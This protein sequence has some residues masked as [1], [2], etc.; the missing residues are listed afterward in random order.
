MRQINCIIP[1]RVSIS[2]SPEDLPDG[3][4]DVELRS[5]IAAGVQSRLHFAW[6]QLQKKYGAIPPPQFHTPEI[7]FSKD[8]PSEARL[9]LR[10]IILRGIGDGISGRAH[11][12]AQPQFILAD[13]KVPSRNQKPVHP[14]EITFKKKFHIRLRDYADLS[15][16]WKDV[17]ARKARNE[18]LDALYADRMDDVLTA[19]AWVVTVKK[20]MLVDDLTEDLTDLVQTLPDNAGKFISWSWN[21]TDGARLDLANAAQGSELSDLPSL[22]NNPGGQLPDGRTFLYFRGKLLF[23]F[24]SLPSLELTTL[25]DLQNPITVRVLL[26][27]LTPWINEPQFFEFFRISWQ[28]YVREFGDNE[29]TLTIQPFITNQKAT[30]ASL[31]YLLRE[32]VV[33]ILAEDQAVFGHLRILNAETVA[34]LPPPARTALLKDWPSNS[35]TSVPG[36]Q[37]NG[38]WEDGWTGAYIHTIVGP[39]LDEP[40]V[41]SYRPHARDAA[42]KA[43]EFL[44]NRENTYHWP[45]RFL[46]FLVTEFRTN[47]YRRNRTPYVAFQYFLKELEQRDGGRWFN[48]LFDAIEAAH[49]GDLYYF[50]LQITQ[51]TNYASHPRVVRNKQLFNARRRDYLANE[52]DI[53]NKQIVLDKNPSYRMGRGDFLKALSRTEKRIEPARLAELQVAVDRISKEFLGK[54]LRGEDSNTYSKEEFAQAVLTQA[55]KEINLSNDDMEKV[56]VTRR[57]KFIDLDAKNEGGIE[58][59]YI[60][61]EYYDQIEDEPLVLVPNSR[62]TVTDSDLEFMLWSWD[63]Q[64]VA[65]FWDTAS[66]VV[67]FGAVLIIAWEIGAIAALVDLAG[68]AAVVITSVAISD[69]IY[70]CTAKHWTLEGFLFASLEG[71]LF[72]LGFRF[73]GGVGNWV[74]ERIGAQSMEKLVLGWVLEKMTT[75]VVG[76]ASS[77]FLITFST[78]ILDILAGRRHGFRSL[79]QYVRSME[80]GAAM[81]V[82]FEFGS[83]PLQPL[84]RGLGRQG[85]ETVGS[86]LEKLKVE[87]I[88]LKTW[89]GLMDEALSKLSGQ[90]RNTLKDL[91]VADVPAAFAARIAEI[92]EGMLTRLESDIL[93]RVARLRRINLTPRATRGLEKLLNAVGGQ[94]E[95]NELFALLNRLQSNPAQLRQLFEA[96]ESL[97]EASLKALSDPAKLNT[98][99]DSFAPKNLPA[100][101]AH[102]KLP[103]PHTAPP[104]PEVH[105]DVKPAE[106]NAAPGDKGAKP[107]ETDNKTTTTPEPPKFKAMDDILKPDGSGFLDPKLDAA[108]KN[109]RVRKIRAGE[110][111]AGAEDWARRQATGESRQALERELGPD[112]ARQGGTENRIKLADVPRPAG[113]SEARLQEAITKLRSRLSKVFERLKNLKDQGIADGTVNSGHFNIGKGNVGEVLSE[114]AQESVLAQIRKTHPK[115]EIIT[116]VKIR[117]M[118]TGGLS[119]TKLFTDNLVGTFSGENLTVHGKFEVKSGSRGGADATTQVFDWVEDRLTDGSQLLIPGHTPIT[120]HPLTAGGPEVVGLAKADAFLITPKG[121]EFYGLQSGDQTVG[122]LFKEGNRIALPYT[123]SELDYITRVIIETLAEP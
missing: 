50:V 25:V 73:G 70:L 35:W 38:I 74:A 87:G 105:D 27:D 46:D 4:N 75:G 34:Q 23:V 49:N 115:A 43:I 51:Q 24:L 36:S 69:L 110:E 88:G 53:V 119:E 40:E 18:E 100:P 90:L 64:K 120:W 29:A 104:K 19:T 116:G 101:P 13:F 20:P 65:A 6:E 17:R 37:A 2:G 118:R 111:P 91:Q 97:D 7:A 15:A 96:L 62:I 44:K 92:S 102:P 30:A 58:R 99:A 81:G 3:L 12:S 77:A 55:A 109:Y 5:S 93:S 61:Y 28:Q 71:Y 39:S 94:I 82:L 67:T 1:I 54:L 108:Y 48:E 14:W 98:F 107:A 83:A 103:P 52:Y 114:P 16:G 80:I 122:T 11:S 9:A 32:E 33:D 66:K 113:L 72:A 79:G 123:A 8:I 63:F 95:D 76:G 57:L 56:T 60:T 45:W 121:S 41:S 31:R 22:Y 78:D 89:K 86:I 68:G 26:R 47:T 85:A 84:L 42:D 21:V 112:F 106:E 59:F 117:V 10:N